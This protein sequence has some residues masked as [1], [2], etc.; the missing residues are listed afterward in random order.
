VSCTLV[1]PEVFF[2][3]TATTFLA[4]ISLGGP[5]AD[6]LGL[7]VVPGLTGSAPLTL[8][9]SVDACS[10]DVAC[11][12]ASEDDVDDDDPGD[13]ELPTLYTA[14]SG[15]LDLTSSTPFNAVGSLTDVTLVEV[16]I[17]EEGVV[18]VVPG[19]ACLTIESFNFT[20][21]PPASDWTCLTE[22]YDEANQGVPTPAC[23]CTCGTDPDCNPPGNPIVGCE[24]GQTCG[25]SGCA[26]VPSAWT[27]PASQYAGGPGNGCDCNC[28]VPDP[29]CDLP[30]EAVDNCSVANSTCN[31]WAACVPPSWACD[32]D[33]LADGGCDCGCGFP[34]PD[35]A[36]PSPTACSVCPELGS[37]ANHGVSPFGCD[38]SL[39]DTENNALCL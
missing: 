17:D 14:T 1:A 9:D 20:L 34:D 35:C 5:K 27:C 28:G 29:D 6:L 23:D 19:G 39:L 30:G 4:D 12:F 26:G 32:P 3:A 21:L 2:A 18:A 8:I 25:A 15:T 13:P 24:D 22:A 33:Y 38:P 11:L 31:R 7:E 10:V 16:T 37:C 36:D